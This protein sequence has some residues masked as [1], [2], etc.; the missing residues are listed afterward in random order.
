[1]TDKPSNMCILFLVSLVITATIGCGCSGPQ[2]DRQKHLKVPRGYVARLDIQMKDRVLGFGPFV[3]YYFKPENPEDLTR[4][5]F[6]C[7]NE[8][9]FYTRD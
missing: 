5:T 3:G 6:V 4:L 1:M 7:Y 8:D 9:S 2:D